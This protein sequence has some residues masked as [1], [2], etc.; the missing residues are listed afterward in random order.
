MNNEDCEEFFRVKSEYGDAISNEMSRAWIE[1]QDYSHLSH[2]NRIPWNTLENRP[3]E[4]GE[5]ILFMALR[6][7][8]ESNDGEGPVFEVEEEDDRERGTKQ[9]ARGVFKRV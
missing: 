1:M 6:S 3:M 5:I 7:F 4:V 2:A 8:R 9:A